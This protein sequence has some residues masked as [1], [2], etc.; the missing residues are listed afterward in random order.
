MKMLGIQADI[1]IGEAVQN[2]RGTFTASY[3]DSLRMMYRDFPHKLF[4]KTLLS[5]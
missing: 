5:R 1:K 2:L 4:S 3:C